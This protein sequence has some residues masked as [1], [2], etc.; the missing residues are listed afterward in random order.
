MSEPIL[1]VGYAPD[2]PP[3]TPGVMVNCGAVVPSTRGFKG[4]PSALSTNTAA[5]AAQCFGAASIRKKDDTTRIFAGTTTNLYEK[6][7]GT[8]VTRTPA[9]TLNGL[10]TTDR[11]RFAQFGD[12]TLCTAKTEIPQFITTATQFAAVTTTAPK[13]AII[14]TVN[15][16]VMVFDV[17]DQGAIFD[18]ADRPDGWW[19]AG[20]GNYTQWTPSITTEAATG[21]LQSTSGKI[22]AGRKFGYQIVVYKQR[23]MY[24]GTYV[25]QPV[26]WD[27]QLI[28]GDAGALSHEVVVNVG[29]PEQPKHIFMGADNFYSF[30][31]G[32]PVPI[33]N[34]L[35]Q[36]VFGELNTGFYY[37]AQALHDVANKR[38]Y[39]YYP[40]G[41]SNKPDKCVVYN[42]LTG[43]WGRDDR[44]IEAVLEY[45]ATG[46]TYDE[47]GASYSTYDALTAL[48][49]D[50]AFFT[51]S[52]PLPGIFDTSHLLKTL[53][54]PAVSSSITTGDYGD[55]QVFTTLKR[56]RPRFINAP[57]LAEFTNFYK[58]NLSDDRTIDTLRMFS[59]GRFDLMRSA[60][61]HSGR[62]DM[63]GDYEIQGFS[64]D[65]M[66]DGEE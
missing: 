35:R 41:S 44:T 24:M 21:T 59:S 26:I 2:L 62:F 49:Y 36:T 18:S 31:G 25:G 6:S 45:L 27:F 7:S 39:F 54:G 43:V 13:A 12:T 38:V 16:F 63:T 17:T 29:T 3:T 9:V 48:S 47:L 5:L 58:N 11:W 64:V 19:C 57:A 4:A 66:A 28:P 40:T 34:P 8:W 1:F 52:A 56:V 22:T 30:D 10:G 60:R 53:S 51:T 23:S 20:K 46:I 33:G 55:D 37:A 50:T 61:W 15:N 65:V 32:R 14:E 42:Y